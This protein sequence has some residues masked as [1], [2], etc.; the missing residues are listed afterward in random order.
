MTTTSD[1]AKKL[2]SLLSNIAPL[3][4][5]FKD[6]HQAAPEEVRDSDN[7][8]APLSWSAEAHQ[9]RIEFI[10]NKLGQEPEY[11]T[12]RKTFDTPDILHRRRR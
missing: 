3:E 2:L 11:I 7:I 1:K 5:I 4:N 8:P 10:K 6:I 12:L 9:K